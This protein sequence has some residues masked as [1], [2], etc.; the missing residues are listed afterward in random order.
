M[1]GAS[2]LLTEARSAD[3]MLPLSLFRAPAVGF[4]CPVGL[5]ANFAYYGLMFVL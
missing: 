4:P 1:A 2:F 5:L 3:P